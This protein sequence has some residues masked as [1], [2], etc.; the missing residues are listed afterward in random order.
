MLDDTKG[1]ILFSAG[2]DMPVYDYVIWE[3]LANLVQVG[4]GFLLVSQV[5]VAMDGIGRVLLDDMQQDK[6]GLILTGK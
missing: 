1:N 3:G 4:G 6:F 5:T 2:M